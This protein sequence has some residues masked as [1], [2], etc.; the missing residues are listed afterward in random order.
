[1]DIIVPFLDEKGKVEMV[2]IN[3]FDEN[4]RASLFSWKDERKLL[5]EGPL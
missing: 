5:E 2:E 4:T 1:M 3:M